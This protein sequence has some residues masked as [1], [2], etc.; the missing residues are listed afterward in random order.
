MALDPPY[1]GAAREVASSD[2]VIQNFGWTDQGTPYFSR[3]T[4]RGTEV[5]VCLSS[6]RIT[7]QSS[8]GREQ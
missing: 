5:S 1:T 7:R 3:L 4:E 8:Y 2:G 6:R